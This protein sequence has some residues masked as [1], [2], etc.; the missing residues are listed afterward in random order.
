MTKGDIYSVVVKI[1][2]LYFFIK[3]IQHFMDLVF[4]VIKY[5]EFSDSSDTLLIYG[6]ASALILLYFILGYFGTFKSATLTK[7]IFNSDSKTI[8]L[9][10]GN[11]ADRRILLKEAGSYL[12]FNRILEISFV[13]FHCLID[14]LRDE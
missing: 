3:F 8:D 11:R 2:G 1:I 12:E 5:K 7:R 4:M 14:P 9:N 6:S 10:L 13:K